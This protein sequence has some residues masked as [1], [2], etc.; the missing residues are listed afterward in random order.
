[1]SKGRSKKPEIWFRQ[2]NMSVWSDYKLSRAIRVELDEIGLKGLWVKALPSSAFESARITSIDELENDEAKG[3][4]F[5]K[6]WI[7]DWNLP[8]AEDPNR[9]LPLPSVSNEYDSVMPLEVKMFIVNKIND[10]DKERLNIPL[11]SE[12]PSSPP[13]ASTAPARSG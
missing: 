10:V 9:I 2:N 12:T 7:I 13:S 8:S 5:M 1:M 6:L 3:N 11:P 4:E